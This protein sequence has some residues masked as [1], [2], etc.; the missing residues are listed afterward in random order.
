[1][2]EKLNR[3]E[4]AQRIL[5]R[6]DPAY[7]AWCDE[8]RTREREKDLRRQG[9]ALAA[10]VASRCDDAF[11]RCA[12]MPTGMPQAASA[13]V[14]MGGDFHA[15]PPMPPP[16]VHPAA[17]DDDMAAPNNVGRKITRSQVG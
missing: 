7:R 10:A 15:F 1:M 13:P 16:V 5:E 12:I 2:R 14:G 17:V 6:K 8:E 4:R 9:E 3:V 11:R